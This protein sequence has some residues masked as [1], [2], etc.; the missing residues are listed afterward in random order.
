MVPRPR[1][2]RPRP[3]RLNGPGPAPTTGALADCTQPTFQSTSSARSLFGWSSPLHEPAHSRCRVP[4]CP[5]WELLSKRGA[6]HCKEPGNAEFRSG[7]QASLLCTRSQTEAPSGVDCSPYP[8]EEVPHRTLNWAQSA[9]SSCPKSAAT[10]STHAAASRDAVRAVCQK[11]DS[12]EARDMLSMVRTQ[13]ADER[14]VRKE[15]A[16]K[17]A[18][19]QAE[20]RA[21]AASGRISTPPQSQFTGGNR[22]QAQMMRALVA[23]RVAQSSDEI[24]RIQAQSGWQT[25]DSL[26]LSSRIGRQRES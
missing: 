9:I 1:P 25:D 10:T 11:P 15:A 3:R 16:E 22:S 21:Q 26:T 5:L 7:L 8:N 20:W 23:S 12:S 18:Q 4:D 14:A 6:A 17:A 13:C 19:Q 24:V 2:R